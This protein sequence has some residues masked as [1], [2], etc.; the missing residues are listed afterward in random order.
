M[1]NQMECPA[2]LILACKIDLTINTYNSSAQYKLIEDCEKIVDNLVI[3]DYTIAKSE[4]M[5]DSDWPEIFAVV[6]VNK[7]YTDQNEAVENKIEKI[8]LTYDNILTLC[9]WRNNYSK[10]ITNVEKLRQKNQIESKGY[11]FLIGWV[12]DNIAS[13]CWLY[14]L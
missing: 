6:K 11:L 9:E 7:K 10:E 8:E 4:K 12:S 13:C 2:L 14:A 1:I 3:T 5:I